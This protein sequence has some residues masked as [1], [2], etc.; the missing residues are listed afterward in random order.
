MGHH[1][2]MLLKLFS[3]EALLIQDIGNWNTSSV[4]DM[5]EYV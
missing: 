4:I 3:N 5:S 2:N 1:P